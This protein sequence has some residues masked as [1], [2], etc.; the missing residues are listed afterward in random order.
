MQARDRTRSQT[1]PGEPGA[2]GV[3]QGT[4]AG[5]LKALPSDS[6]GFARGC[7]G[8]P[9]PPNPRSIDARPL[10]R[11]RRAPTSAQA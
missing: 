9:P 2:V 11:P 7:C 6:S 1:L 5:N 8:I 10:T 3:A 4:L